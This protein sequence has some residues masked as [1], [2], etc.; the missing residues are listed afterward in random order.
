VQ[1]GKTF[2]GIAYLENKVSILVVV[3]AAGTLWGKIKELSKCLE[4]W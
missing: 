3:A 2:G 4:N 1:G